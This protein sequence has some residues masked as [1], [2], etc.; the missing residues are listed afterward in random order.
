[1]RRALVPVGVAALT[2]AAAGCGEDDPLGPLRLE[3]PVRARHRAAIIELRSGDEPGTLVAADVVDGI[4]EPVMRNLEPD[5]V[6]QV[7]ALLYEVPLAE[8][9]IP[10]GAV[11]ALAPGSDGR[12]LP[13]PSEIHRADV[14]GA[15]EASWTALSALPEDLGSV[16][17]PPLDLCARFSPRGVSLGDSASPTSALALDDTWA[18]VMTEG[19]EVFFVD[20]ARVVRQAISTPLSSGY[21]RADGEVWLGGAGGAIFRGVFTADPEPQLTL[22]REGTVSSAERVIDLVGAPDGA[23]EHFAMTSNDDPDEVWGA[24]EWFDGE[25]WR[26]PGLRRNTPHDATWVAR[27]FGLFASFFRE[28]EVFGVRDGRETSIVVSSVLLGS[29]VVIEQIPGLGMVAATT[30]GD[31]H[32]QPPGGDWRRITGSTTQRIG[33]V[34]G[35]DGGLVYLRGTAVAHY[36]PDGALC[37]DSALLSPDRTSLNRMDVVGAD[38]IVPLVAREG[39][40]VSEQQ[41]AW[42]ERQP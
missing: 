1:M 25:R 37:E 35:Y 27:G 9:S 32:V 33:D 11:A 15:A 31:V 16:R 40:T 21:V 10:P 8:L 5:V 39:A 12:P 24:F 23:I 2:L 17:L 38:V 19:P 4:I 18:L 14:D 34:H 26:Q 36:P 7:T 20:G 13:P 41:V 28:G 30:A 3:L 29:V 42:F 6:T 22:T